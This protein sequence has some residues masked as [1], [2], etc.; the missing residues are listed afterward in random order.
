VRANLQFLVDVGLVPT[1]AKSLQSFLEKNPNSAL[2]SSSGVSGLPNVHSDD[3][4]IDLVIRFEGGSDPPN[5]D[6]ALAS[7]F[8]IS[9]S[10]LT[11]YLGKPASIDDLRNLSVETARDIY[12]KLYL[13]AATSAI[14]SVQVKAAY[15]GLST[16]MGTRQASKLFQDA[17]GK[18]DGLPIDVDGVL[19]PQTVQRINAIDPNLLIET[20][21]CGAAKYYESLP[22]FAKFGVSWLNRLRAFSPVTLKGICPELQPNSSVAGTTPSKP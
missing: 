13:G 9:L 19:G 14:A 12:K 7:K 15:L 11:G 3:D 17:I 18:V 8:G 1:Y 5:D 22:T 21:N 20:A 2:P 16:N 10:T 4:A 6:P